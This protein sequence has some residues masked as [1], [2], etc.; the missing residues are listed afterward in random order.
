[1]DDNTNDDFQQNTDEGNPL[2]EMK[3]RQKLPED[4]APPFSAPDGVQDRL[5][6]THQV[7]DTNVDNMERYDAGIEGASGVDLPGE[8][9]DETD[10]PLETE[11]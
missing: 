3:D 9:G 4:N 7:T 8:A 11:E 2:E 6:D 1:M 5:N 10:D